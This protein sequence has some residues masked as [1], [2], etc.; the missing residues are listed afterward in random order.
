MKKWVCLFFVVAAFI[1]CKK[2]TT[3]LESEEIRTDSV[4]RFDDQKMNVDSIVVPKTDTITE[5]KKEEVLPEIEKKKPEFAIVQGEKYSIWPH[6]VSDSLVKKFNKEFNASQ[7]YIIAAL[8]RI[9]TDHLASRDS[10]IVP[11]TF[12]DNFLDYSPFPHQVQI[13]EEVDKFLIFSYPIQAFAVYEKGSLK[14]WG[15]TNMGK[16]AS[17]TPRGLF[18][19]NWKG[20]KVRSTVDDEWILNWNFNIHNTG[21]IGFH[22]YAMP[23]YP[24]S[25]SC[26][27][28]LDADAQY[29]YNWADQWILADKQTVKVKGTPVIVYGDYNFGVKGIWYQLYKDP[30]ITTIS[31]ETL[32]AL[33]TP[34]KEEILKAQKIRQEQTQPKEQVNTEQGVKSEVKVLD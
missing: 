34:H 19:T 32:T 31:E 5:V 29:L 6:K 2:E 33:I 17:Q 13:L 25:H 15:P 9:D 18:F 8:N 10:L 23:G 30:N 12:F 14:K 22:Q 24:A 28:L 26:L 27:R 4:L 20:R 16:K 11:N 7:K 3:A 1:Q 21:G